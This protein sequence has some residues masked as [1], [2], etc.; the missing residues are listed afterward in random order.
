MKGKPKLVLGVGPYDDTCMV[1]GRAQWGQ[2]VPVGFQHWR[3]DECRVGSV[4]WMAKMERIS[5][6]PLQEELYQTYRRIRD[7]QATT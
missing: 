1:C 3:H 4:E 2:W 6:T 5:R 7:G